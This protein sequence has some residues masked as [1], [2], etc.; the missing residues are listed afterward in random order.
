M[1]CLPANKLPVAHGNILHDWHAEVIAIRAFNRPLLDEC[2]LIS[3]P[4][5]PTSGLLRKVSPDLGPGRGRRRT[6]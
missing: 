6:R 4:P 5:Y 2:T 1:K 3:T